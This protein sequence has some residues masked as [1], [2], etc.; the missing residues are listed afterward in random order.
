MAFKS[1]LSIS[2]VY[3]K[4]QKRKNRWIL[5][6]DDI[7]GKVIN[8][9]SSV[10]AQITT[11][12]AGGNPVSFTTNLNSSQI[13]KGI[14]EINNSLAA[15]QKLATYQNIDSTGVDANRNLILSLKTASRPN[16]SIGE[17]E[18]HRLNEKAFFP[19]GKAEYQ[20]LEISFYDTIGLNT[21]SVLYD[22]MEA[23]Y[24][25]DT[26]SV[27][28]KSS[29]A[30]TGRLSMLSPKGTIIEQWKMFNLWPTK[31]TFGNL[32]YSS[33][34][35]AMVNMSF[36][37]DIAVVQFPSDSIIKPEPG[38]TEGLA[39]SGWGVPSATAFDKPEI[40]WAET[41]GVPPS[42]TFGDN[43]DN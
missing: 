12:D 15:G 38:T 29:L 22:W 10:Q 6:F 35:A 4:E 17:T 39:S 37:Y 25:P 18:L 5:E 11:E 16:Y 21:G 7:P 33:T 30:T 42:A 36:R 20:P 9:V 31:I 34:N 26:G 23:V 3:D 32:D 43:L 2:H 24:D 27:A 1:I 13:N 41:D 19:A 14:E 8:A 28:Y 40:T